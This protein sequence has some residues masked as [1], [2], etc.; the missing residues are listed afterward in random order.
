MLVFSFKDRIFDN[1]KNLLLYINQHVNSEDYAI[2]LKRTKKFKL[3]V[4]CKTWIICDRD[5]KFHERA[6][7]HRRHDS[8]KHIKCFFFIIAKLDNENV[9]S[10]IFEIRNKEHNHVSSMFDMS[11][12]CLTLIQF[13]DKWRWLVRLKIEF[14]Y[15]DIYTIKLTSASITLTSAN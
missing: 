7:E 15:I 3:Q 10:W 11:Q 13:W 12:V 1:L 5:K 2:V 8:N 4:T 14:W 9:D 6:E